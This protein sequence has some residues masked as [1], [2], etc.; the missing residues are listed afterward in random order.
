M[1]KY[2]VHHMDCRHCG[3]PQAI[4]IPFTCVPVC[5]NCRKP[6]DGFNTF[7][8]VSKVAELLTD[9]YRE[10]SAKNERFSQKRS[11]QNA[12]SA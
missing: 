4:I 5:R 12:Q 10:I 9:I 2:H 11:N 3:N 8:D 6:V 7:D 1:A